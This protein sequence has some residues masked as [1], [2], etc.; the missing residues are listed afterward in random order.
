MSMNT[1]KSLI[2]TLRAENVTNVVLTNG[3]FS[4]GVDIFGPTTLAG[5]RYVAD[6]ADKPVQAVI[7]FMNSDQSMNDLVTQRSLQEG[8]EDTGYYGPD[9]TERE[10]GLVACLVDEQP[11]AVYVCPI[12]GLTPFDT[13]FL[14][15]QCGITFDLWKWGY[16]GPGQNMIVGSEFANKTYAFAYPGQIKAYADD[17]TAATV[18]DNIVVDLSQETDDEG[19]PYYVPP[20]S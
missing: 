1:L 17:L 7:V 4:Q 18:Q 2:A 5:A 16:G 11:Y 15:T 6:K 3:T 12:D 20:A 14:L 8:T 9:E 10:D 19:K 13:Y